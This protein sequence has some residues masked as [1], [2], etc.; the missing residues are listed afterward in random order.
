[1]TLPMLDGMLDTPTDWQSS[2]HCRIESGYMPPCTVLFAHRPVKERKAGAT[3]F[4]SAIP[5]RRL[6]TLPIGA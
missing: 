1:M 3:A 6:A 2:A 4:C 5:G